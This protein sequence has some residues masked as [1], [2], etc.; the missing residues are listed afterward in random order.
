MAIICN[1]HSFL[2]WMTFYLSDGPCWKLLSF[3]FNSCSFSTA[4]ESANGLWN[5]IKSLM[6]RI[7]LLNDKIETSASYGGMS[8]TFFPGSLRPYKYKPAMTAVISTVH[9]PYAK[10]CPLRLDSIWSTERDYLRAK[11]F[12]YVLDRM[13]VLYVLMKMTFK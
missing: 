11:S 9:P 6:R 10:A 12:L 2:E 7:T 8:N 3:S 1:L 13:F 4:L 5:E